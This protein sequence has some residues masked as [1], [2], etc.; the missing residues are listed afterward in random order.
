MTEDVDASHKSDP[1][2]DSPPLTK[3]ARRRQKE[4]SEREGVPS[5]GK[6]KKTQQR[7]KVSDN[8][9]S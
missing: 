2:S 6:S 4:E 8:F 9:L 3:K 5:V 1:P 7:K